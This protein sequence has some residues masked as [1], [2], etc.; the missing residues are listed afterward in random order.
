MS[1]TSRHLVRAVPRRRLR[2]RTRRRR[3]VAAIRWDVVLIGLA[4]VLVLVT[5][6][7]LCVRSMSAR[8]RTHA[9]GLN[10]EILDEESAESDEPIVV[11]RPRL[12]SPQP[13]NAFLTT[14]AFPVDES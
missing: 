4:A 2:P 14:I 6:V 5:I 10:V 13:E 1:T 7:L 3:E 12:D 9:I 8:G 11:Q